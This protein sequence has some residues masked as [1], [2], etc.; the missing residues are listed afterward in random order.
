MEYGETMK[1]VK[2]DRRIIQTA[3]DLRVIKNDHKRDAKPWW[4]YDRLNREIMD[5]AH[6]VELLNEQLIRV[7]KSN[8][9]TAK[10]LRELANQLK[11]RK[12]CKLCKEGKQ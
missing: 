2:L 1:S 5:I 8:K 10:E 11:L 6:E 3:I 7:V 9:E 4:K 12:L